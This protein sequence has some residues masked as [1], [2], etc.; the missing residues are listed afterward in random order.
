MDNSL[1]SF[2]AF[3]SWSVSWKCLRVSVGFSRRDRSLR[4]VL[5]LLVALVDWSLMLPHLPSVPVLIRLWRL[6]SGERLPGL[7]LGEHA[8]CERF[9]KHVFNLKC[10]VPVAGVSGWRT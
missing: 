2:R 5:S 6:G 3:F 10:T 9:A 1:R 7:L 4:S 8:E